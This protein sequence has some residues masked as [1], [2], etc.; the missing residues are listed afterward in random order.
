[1]PHRTTAFILPTVNCLVELSEMP[2][3]VVSLEDIEVRLGHARFRVLVLCGDCA[4]VYTR[5]SWEDH[6]QARIR[7]DATAFLRTS[8]L[9]T[10]R[11]LP[12]SFL[13]CR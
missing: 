13:V 9:L 8:L 1:M 12:F 3:T 11:Y 5:V 4:A 6:S 10:V 7:T 2:F